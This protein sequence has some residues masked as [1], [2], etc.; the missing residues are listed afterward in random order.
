[1]G[2]I[3]R[4][5]FERLKNP[6]REQE[7][8]MTCPSCHGN[9]SFSIEDASTYK[10]IMCRWCGGMGGVVRHVYQAFLRAQRIYNNK[11]Q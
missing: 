11:S 5:N 2:R 8:L 6:Y 9:G 1:M 4:A 10:Q 3:R 7:T